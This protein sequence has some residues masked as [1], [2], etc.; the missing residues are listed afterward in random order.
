M[1]KIISLFNF[2]KK[3]EVQKE[4]NKWAIAIFLS[5]TIL[6]VAFFV[7]AQDDFS[8]ENIFLD[9][10]QDG[11]SDNEEKVWGT[12]PANR[13]TDNDGYSDG[14]EVESGFNPLKPAPG[15]KLVEEKVQSAETTNNDAGSPSEQTTESSAEENVS[16]TEEF[17]SRIS[18]IIS[19]SEENGTEITMEN[20]DEVVQSFLADNKDVPALPEVNE[21]EIKIKKQ[22]YDSL[23]ESE[24]VARKKED[25]VKYLTA[26]IYLIINNLPYQISDFNDLEKIPEQIIADAGSMSGGKTILNSEYLGNLS[27]RAKKALEQIKEVEVPENLLETHKEGLQLVLYAIDL[28]KEINAVPTDDPMAFLLK[29][30]KA[31]TFFSLAEDFSEKIISQ[32][33]KLGITELP[34]NL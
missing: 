34:I 23:S 15:D 24:R 32:L 26:M 7:S 1:K 28:E 14:A 30:S 9:S 12:D 31:E 22:D 29:L 3:V 25:D 4:N 5:L 18:N 13:D 11:L 19:S 16:L 20:L 21:E 8:G 2:W 33:E 17:S 6:S 10:D 27:E